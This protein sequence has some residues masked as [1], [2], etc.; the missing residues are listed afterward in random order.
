MKLPLYILVS[1]LAIVIVGCMGPDVEWVPK[2]INIID[3]EISKVT[4]RT[5]VVTWITDYDSLSRV[6]V[7]HQDSVSNTILD[8]DLTREHR[9]ELNKLEPSTFYLLI[10]QS[11][12]G[13]GAAS[14]QTGAELLFQTLDE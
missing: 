10:I 8:T 6:Q 13:R 1:F 14:F 7:M 9:I 4:S 5:A 3:S 2:T 11:T 12:N